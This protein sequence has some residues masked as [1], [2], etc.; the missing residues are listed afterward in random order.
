MRTTENSLDTRAA[1]EARGVE[2]QPDWAYFDGSVFTN[3]T[4][5]LT[6]AAS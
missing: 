3:A 6:Q 1:F 2:Q 4:L 5:R